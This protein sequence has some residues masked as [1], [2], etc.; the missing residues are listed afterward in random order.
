[1]R[2]GAVIGALSQLAEKH[3]TRGFWKYYKMLRRHDRRWNHK[4]IYRVYCAMKL[5]HRRRPK[6]RIPK[7]E[8]VPLYVPQRPQQ[9]WSADFMSDALYCGRSF[10]TF[11]ITDDF[12]REAVHIEID[13]SLTSTRLVRVFEQLRAERGLPDVLRT[14]NGL[15]ATAFGYD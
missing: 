1:V 4:R 9:V 7:R 3:P 2:D 5:N 6:R 13:T 11:N 8:R 12:N 15:L 14:D 10:R